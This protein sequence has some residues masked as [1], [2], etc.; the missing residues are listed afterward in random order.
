MFHALSRRLGGAALLAAALTIAAPVR[1]QQTP[2]AQANAMSL[3]APRG[4]HL[5]TVVARDYA[6]A[7][8][9]TIP[10]GLT[11]F[12]L[13]DEGAE[14]HHFMLARLDQGH[15]VSQFLAAM[16]SDDI[17]SWAHFA[18]GPNAA[19]PK[20][21]SMVTERLDAGHYVLFCV[22]P[23][24]DGTPHV[25]K[26]MLKELTVVPSADSRAPDP[27]SDVAVTLTDYDFTFSKPLS[28]GSHTIA[29]TNN[30]GQPHEMVIVKLPPGKKAA[31]FAAW[32]MKPNGP[33][34]G[35]LAGG[36][37]T[38]EP[39]ATVYM[40]SRFEPGAYGLICFVPDVQ[41]GQPHFA[42]GMAKDIV[43]K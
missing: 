1:A 16:K 14:P 17:P 7:L 4:S 21:Q 41:D 6:F 35:A 28:A 15:D 18:G 19:M 8:P 10:A 9:D 12:L 42:H 29:V 25:A 11:T 3:P 5:V 26:G 32:G 39:G 13:R 22:V 34:P 2:D 23:S 24:P 33:P 36:V 37:T 43:V 31:D 20:G 38:I 40:T 30:A 27:A